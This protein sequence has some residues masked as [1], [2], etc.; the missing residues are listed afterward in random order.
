MDQT[1]NSF[2]DRRSLR[3]PFGLAHSAR[4]EKDQSTVGI[5]KSRN[6]LKRVL[7]VGGRPTLQATLTS[8]ALDTAESGP[9]SVFFLAS[10]S[11]APR[12]V[13][14]LLLRTTS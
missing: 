1:V 7:S 3:G 8:S 11:C 9:A 5:E 10:L 14:A 12:A 13:M 2:I 6:K 4:P